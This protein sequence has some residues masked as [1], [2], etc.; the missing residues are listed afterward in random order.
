MSKKEIEAMLIV[1]LRDL[2]ETQSRKDLI[3]IGEE[4]GRKMG[5]SSSFRHAQRYRLRLST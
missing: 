4:R 1:E 2:E 3:A 5:Y